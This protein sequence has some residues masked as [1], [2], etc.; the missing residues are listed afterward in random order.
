MTQLV[1]Q[2]AEP[3]P[4][5]AP[6]C[7]ALD[8]SRASLYRDRQPR[9]CPGARPPR[10]P[11]HRALTA[12]EQRNVLETLNS[13]RFADMAPGAVF[14]AL[15]DQDQY[16][17]SPRTMYRILREND[18][19]RERRDQLR[20][21]AYAKT[22][23]LADGPNQVWSW[24]ITKL[25]GPAKWNYY[26]LY[27]IIDIFSRRVVGWMVADRESAELA[28]QL[29]LD[30]I[31]KQQVDPTGLTIHADRGASMRSKAV[32]LLLS[33]LGVTKTHSRPY[34]SN[35]NPFSESQFKTMK[36]R[37][38]F[39]ERFGSLE[40]ARAFCNRFFEWYNTEHYHGGIAMLTPHTV[41]YGQSQ[42]ALDARGAVLQKAYAANPERFVRGVPQV[43]KLP[44][45]VW[46]NPPAP[47]SDPTL[48]SESAQTT[49]NNS[50]GEVSHLR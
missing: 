3:V 12:E 48:R 30:T 7:R 35:D 24:D 2:S 19:V 43:G 38:D 45:A 8:V 49:L 31:K 26:H 27:V 46:I 22:E 29:I 21:P 40:D 15:L 11:S 37:P 9:P 13:P 47:M 6:L 10:K 5:I 36:Y 14:A 39:P 1:E 33:D 17:C 32:A 28:K 42:T 23:L 41:H 20:H 34:T 25:K 18:Q 50:E 16:L 4:P 44:E